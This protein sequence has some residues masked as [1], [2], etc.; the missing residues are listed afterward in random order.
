ME[1]ED[2]N[3]SILQQGRLSKFNVLLGRVS[4]KDRMKEG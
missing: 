3:G 1:E 4:S 2:K